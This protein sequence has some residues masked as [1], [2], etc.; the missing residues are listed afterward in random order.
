MSCK[1]HICLHSQHWPSGL[2]KQTQTSKARWG[3]HGWAAALFFL[4]TAP[5]V[6]TQPP[7]LHSWWNGLKMRLSISPEQTDQCLGQ[8][9][10]HW[11]HQETWSALSG[12]SGYTRHPSSEAA[13]AAVVLGRGRR[14]VEWPFIILQSLGE[15]GGECPVCIFFFLETEMENKAAA[16]CY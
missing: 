16:S 5:M 7:T 8:R 2:F 14:P 15:R 10:L 9:G 12:L 4:S 11:Q 6:W 3:P 13:V 1:Y